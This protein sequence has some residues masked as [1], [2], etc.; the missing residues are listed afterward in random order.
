MKRTFLTG[1]LAGLDAPPPP[2]ITGDTAASVRTAT[3]P[4]LDGI[5]NAWLLRRSGLARLGV[6]A[7]Q[8]P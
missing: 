6:L 2:N 3:A 8:D 5:T 7:A 1:F 4:T